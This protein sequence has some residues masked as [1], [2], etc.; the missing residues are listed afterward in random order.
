MTSYTNRNK[1]VDYLLDCYRSGQWER[2]EE[3]LHVPCPG[4]G[5]DE[6]YSVNL[7]DLKDHC[8]RC[9]YGGKLHEIVMGC[10]DSWRRLK[11][12]VGQEKA[13]PSTFEIAAPL[14][15]QPVLE[16]HGTQDPILTALK[17]RAMAYCNKRGLTTGQVAQYRVSV[18]RGINRVYF[19]YWTENGE[20]NFW[21]GRSLFEGVKPK[22]V[23]PEHSDKPLFG[24]HVHK[25]EGDAVCLVEGVFDHLATI[26]SYAMMGCHVTDSQVK[27]LKSDGIK[28]IFLIGDADAHEKAVKIQGQLHRTRLFTVHV[29]KLPRLDPSDLGVEFMSRVVS[30]VWEYRGSPLGRTFCYRDPK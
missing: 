7:V 10:R 1:I 4:C 27:Q 22:T 29:V 28:T 30:E 14:D 16:P 15:F 26:W 3:Q 17:R 12:N 9:G 8:F 5:R 25:V 21:M 24:R 23:E 19:P 13:I 6:H 2:R 18:V 11:R 20:C